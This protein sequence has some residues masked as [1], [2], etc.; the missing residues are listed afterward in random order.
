[1]RKKDVC[2]C[3]RFLTLFYLWCWNVLKVFSWSLKHWNP[4]A[5]ATVTTQQPDQWTVISSHICSLIA[6]ASIYSCL[7]VSRLRVRSYWPGL[8]DLLDVRDKW[9]MGN[10]W[11][12]KDRKA[13]MYVWGHGVSVH[14]IR[15]IQICHFVHPAPSCDPLGFAVYKLGE[16]CD[17]QL[18]ITNRCVCACTTVGRERQWCPVGLTSAQK[19]LVQQHLCHT[20]FCQLPSAISTIEPER[21]EHLDM[22]GLT[23]NNTHPLGLGMP[24]SSYSGHLLEEHLRKRMF[25]N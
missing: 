1:M 7:S 12:G 4:C 5:V 18:L 16:C 25:R 24:H 20:A 23:M 6:D 2:R 3:N 13:E 15:V 19:L 17:P 22:G 9:D 8:L 10:S 21:I 11:E 14:T